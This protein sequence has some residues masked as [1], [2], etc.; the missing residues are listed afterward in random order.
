MAGKQN[1]LIIGAGGGREHTLAW[2]L[3]K[4]PNIGKLYIAPS[5]GGTAQVATTADL[6]PF[7]KAAVVEFAQANDIGLVVAASDDVLAAGL[8]DACQ[9]AGLRAFGPTQAAARIESSKV[10]AKDLMAKHHIPTAGYQTFTDLAAAEAYIRDHALPLVIKAN[11]L[12]LGKGV[13]VCQTRDEAMRALNEI[14]G[15]KIFGESGSS[16]VVEE[17][18]QG[19]EISVQVLC[20][21]KTAVILPVSQD[22]KPIGTGD[23]GPNTGGMGTYAPVP[24]VTPAMIEQIRT[25]IVE[26]VLAGLAEAD[27]P[28]K[29][30]LYPG[31]MV[32]G[33]DIKVVEFN[34]RFGDPEPQSYLR[35]LESDLLEILNACVDGTLA[36][37]DMKWSDESAV[38]VIVASG[39]YPGKYAKGLPI[40]GVEDAE[41]LPGVVV[42]HA[43][44]KRGDD[45]RL[46]TNGGRVLGVSAVGKTLTEARANAYNA[47]KRIQ[48]DGMQYRIDIGARPAPKTA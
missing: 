32:D 36:E 13:Y 12:A 35:L 6:N 41:E 46:V 16:V 2:M 43:G 17:F 40:T 7:D 4:S 20:D 42:F 31:L 23:V 28:F 26:P 34:A 21:G 27:A 1:V 45:G 25:T 38:C 11:G 10:F 9:A 44:T 39:G 48:F 33:Q 18:M 3:A 22:H 15:E 5:N 14:M 37:T 30:M 29:G 8:V 47:V 19:Q 24:W